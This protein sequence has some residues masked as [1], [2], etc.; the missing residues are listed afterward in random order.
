MRRESHLFE[1]NRLACG[2]DP[3]HHVFHAARGRD[4]GDPQFDV[5]RAEFLE[6]DLAV[7]RL[8]LFRDVQVAHDLEARDERRSI[9]CRHLDVILQIAILAEADL[10]LRLAGIGFDMDVRNAQ[11]VRVDDDLV[12]E[13]HEF[14]V[15][16]RRDIV[17]R[18]ALG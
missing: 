11:V 14:I 9:A 6:L 4:R 18:G 1:R 12:D 5:E 16:C 10:G 3:H 17:G 13:L 7:L 15:G 2:E 8:A